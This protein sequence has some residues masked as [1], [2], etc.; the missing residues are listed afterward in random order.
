MSNSFSD[1]ES[2]LQVTCVTSIGWPHRMNRYGWM[3][4]EA[5]LIVKTTL[6]YNYYY[7]I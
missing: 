3:V 7:A 5:F 2:A 4:K 6:I 1:I